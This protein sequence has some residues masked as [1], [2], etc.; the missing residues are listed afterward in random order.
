TPYIGGYV[1]PASPTW[2][3]QKIERL[4]ALAAAG[5]SFFMFDFLS[6]ERGGLEPFDHDRSELQSCWSSGHGHSVPITR[7]EHAEGVMTVVRAVKSEFPQLTVE[8]H[9]RIAGEFLPLYYQHGAEHS[10]DELW[11]FEYMWDPYTDLLSNKALSLY[12]YNLAYD[13]PLY[14]HINSAHDSP[15]MLAFWWY[16]SCCRHLGIGGLAEGDEQWPRLVDAMGTY[17]RLQP[18]FANGRFVGL[19]R[20]THLH[21]LEDRRSAVLTA[22]NLGGEEVQRPVTVDIS[23]LGIEAVPDVDVTSHPSSAVVRSRAAHG[24]LALDLAIPPLSPVV[25]ELGAGF[26]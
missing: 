26:V 4:R 5:V 23:V 15:T 19:D 8:A 6:Y 7:E 25:V 11:G 22:F 14:L 24:S 3:R 17:R 9:D 16:A 21:V 2:Q 20:L 18:W 10:H 1:C 12:E 13:I